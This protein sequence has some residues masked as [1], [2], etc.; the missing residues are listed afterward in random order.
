MISS[1]KHLI[2]A[3][4]SPRR[5]E[6]LDAMQ[7]SVPDTVFRS[8]FDEVM[9]SSRSPEEV[10]QELGYGNALWVAER[11]PGA[12]AIGSDTIVTVN[13]IQLGKAD[14]EAHAREMLKMQAGNSCKVTSSVVLVQVNIKPDNSRVIKHYIGSES[15]YI[16]CKPYDEALVNQ[17]IKTGAW[18]DK[19]AS[20]GIQSGG[21]ILADSIE[22]HYDTILGLPTHTLVEFLEKI[23]VK[24]MS[25]ELEPPVPYKQ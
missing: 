3:S 16:H 21:D 1:D 11:N 4:Q 8:E 9:D 13:G 15:A 18:H 12:W 25:V 19:A 14:D 7:L 23:G 2:L 17:Y 6:L 22:G 5:K 20:F 10:S 24:G